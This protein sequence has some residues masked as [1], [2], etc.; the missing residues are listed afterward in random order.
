MESCKCDILLF[1]EK[2]QLVLNV[3]VVHLTKVKWHDWV[4]QEQLKKAEMG[5]VANLQKNKRKKNKQKFL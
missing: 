2:Y 1:N 4:E 3:R 5:R